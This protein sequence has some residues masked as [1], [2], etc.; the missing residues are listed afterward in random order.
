MYCLHVHVSVLASPPPPHSSEY[1]FELSLDS[2]SPPLGCVSVRLCLPSARCL[3]DTASL[4]LLLPLRGRGEEGGD[5]RA[6]QQGRWVHRSAGGLLETA[7]V[8]CGP[9]LLKP[10]VDV[11]GCSVQ[12]REKQPIFSLVDTFQSVN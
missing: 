5:E 4:S 9:V 12:V 6:G 1:Q 2:G 3:S 7:E 11:T 8:L 10:L